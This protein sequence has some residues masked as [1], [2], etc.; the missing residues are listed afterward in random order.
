MINETDLDAFAEDN[1]DALQAASEYVRRAEKGLP[2]D[3]FCDGA[4]GAKL[5][6]RGIYAMQ[7]IMAAQNDAL[8]AM[9]AD[10]QA[11]GADAMRLHK[12]DSKYNG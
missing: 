10:M 2:P 4:T 5:V 11:K 8:I 12:Q 6:A 9:A 7:C 3:R 1:A